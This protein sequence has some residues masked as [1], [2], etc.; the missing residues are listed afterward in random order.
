MIPSTFRVTHSSESYPA[1]LSTASLFFDQNI[2]NTTSIYIH[3][4]NKRIVNLQPRYTCQ[5]FRLY[6]NIFQLTFND[7]SVIILRAS[8]E[9]IP[10]QPRIRS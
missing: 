3:F 1:V 10:L 8:I 2:P 5:F 9:F 4:R 7:E 6:Y